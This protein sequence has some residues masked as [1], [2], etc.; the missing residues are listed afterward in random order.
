MNFNCYSINIFLGR[1]NSA[2]LAKNYHLKTGSNVLINQFVIIVMCFKA[3]EFK[4]HNHQ[5]N[6]TLKLPYSTSQ[7]IF[8]SIA[9]LSSSA[10]GSTGRQ[11][12]HL[13]HLAWPISIR[14]FTKQKP[15][16]LN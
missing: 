4:I 3:C 14:L 15:K 9:K 1:N 5:Y 8:F 10:I 16:L 7:I 2:F 12:K 13:K 6:N 11:G